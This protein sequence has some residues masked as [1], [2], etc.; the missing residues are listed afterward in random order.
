MTLQNARVNVRMPKYL[1]AR[2]EFNNMCSVIDCIVRNQSCDGALIKVESPVEL[3]REFDLHILKTD[4]FYRCAT[5]W[6][7]SKALGVRFLAN[8]APRR[9]RHLHLV[10]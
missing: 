7:E 9:R 10:S 3:P 5:V 4:E 8:P 1:G 2:I 6:D